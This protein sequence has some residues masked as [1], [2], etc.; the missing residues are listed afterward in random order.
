MEAEDAAGNLDESYN[1]NVTLVLASNPNGVTLGGD[2]RK[3]R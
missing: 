1:G 2:R 3:R